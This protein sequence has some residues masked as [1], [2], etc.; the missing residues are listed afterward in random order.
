MLNTVLHLNPDN[1]CMKSKKTKEEQMIL[2]KSVQEI[3]VSTLKENEQLIEKASIGDHL[4]HVVFFMA[5]A[6]LIDL[7][8]IHEAI[9]QYNDDMIYFKDVYQRAVAFYV[10]GDVLKKSL[11]IIQSNWANFNELT[12]ALQSTYRV[13]EMKDRV[14]VESKKDLLFVTKRLQE[15]INNKLL[16]NGVTIMDI[17]STYI[18]FDVTIG[19]DTIIYPNTFITGQSQIG[20]DCVIGPDVRISDAII[21]NDTTIKDS[22]VLESRVGSNTTVGPYAYIRPKSDIGSH[23]KVGDFVEVKN[24]VIGDG[25]KMSHL[26]YIGD[27]DLGKNIN[28]GCGVV[29]VNYNGKDKNR[30]TIGDDSFIGCNSNIVAPV[31]IEPLAYV[32]AGTT[33]TKDVQS[34]ALAVGR[35]KQENKA[36]WVEKRQL[37]K[38]K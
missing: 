3:I 32:A 10:P 31:T 1:S 19:M 2:G 24:A 35:A 13:E 8:Y 4:D 27:A 17:Y 20:E 15:R 30:S 9:E 14:V 37:I 11:D 12:E 21:G 7:T 29:F 26:S 5:H 23:V 25:T 22:T 18:D 36:G 28:V 34:G 33:V 38:K 16:D 6:P